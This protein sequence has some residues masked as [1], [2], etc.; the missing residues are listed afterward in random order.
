MNFSVPTS[1]E[2]KDEVILYDPVSST[3]TEP[4]NDQRLFSLP[5]SIIYSLVAWMCMQAFK[6]QRR[7][8]SHPLIATTRDE[9]RNDYLRDVMLFVTIAIC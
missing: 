9:R 5:R 2:K 6:T 4:S 8:L 3:Y 7:S 1:A